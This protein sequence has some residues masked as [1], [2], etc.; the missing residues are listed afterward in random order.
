MAG[1]LINAD[2]FEKAEEKKHILVFHDPQP[3]LDKI[4]KSF[5]SHL[6]GSEAQLYP[7]AELFIWTVIAHSATWLRSEESLKSPLRG[8]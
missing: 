7:C 8:H 2:Q 1:A 5:V 6:H 4:K 3:E